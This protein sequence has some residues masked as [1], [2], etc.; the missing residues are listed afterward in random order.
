MIRFLLSKFPAASALLAFRAYGPPEPRPLRTAAGF[1]IAIQCWSFKE[2][3]LYEAAEMAAAAGASALELYPGQRL[4]G[5][6]GGHTLG[7]DLDEG[8]I[9]ELL[10]HFTAHHL[11]ALSLGVIAIPNDDAAARRVFRFAKKLGLEGITTESLG[12]LDRVEQ[13][14]AEF[15]LRVGFH[16]H[17]RPTALWHPDPLARALEGR[18]PHLGFCADIGHWAASGLDPLE[19]IRRIAPRVRSLHL[20][21]RSLIGEPSRDLPLGTGVLPIREILGE[22]VRHGFT[23]NASIEYEFNWTSSLPEIAQSVGYL[24]ALGSGPLV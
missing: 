8:R 20:K 6:H 23:G 14:A 7:P 4:G 10:A 16:N 2:F 15:D 1:S 19:I 3:S 17:P 22:L 11:T 18:H 24:R 21:D 12:S 5:P 13:L 9:D